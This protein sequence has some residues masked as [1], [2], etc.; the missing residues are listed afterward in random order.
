MFSHVLTYSHCFSIFSLFLCFQCHCSHNFY[1]FTLFSVSTGLHCS[2]VFSATVFFLKCSHMFGHV[3]KLLMCPHY[4][5]P[6]L[7]PLFSPILTV[8]VFLVPL[9]SLFLHA[10]S[11]L[12]CSH[13][14][15]LSSCPLYTHMFSLF[16]LLS[17][18]LT[19]LICFHIFSQF[20]VLWK[21]DGMVL[22]VSL[23][24]SRII[25]ALKNKPFNKSMPD[26][27]A[28]LFATK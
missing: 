14:F 16:L 10:L 24:F 27:V 13:M 18:I 3:L 11:V 5:Y 1:M 7:F 2:C 20:L 26:I 28:S 21:Q 15:S 12:K 4:C 17:H 6:Y 9:F 8:L 25:H 19:V 23:P 22:E